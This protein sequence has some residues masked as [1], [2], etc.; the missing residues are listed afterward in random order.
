MDGSRATYGICPAGTASLSVTP[1]GLAITASPVQ[2]AQQLA[3][4]GLPINSGEILMG[5]QT[6]VHVAPGANTQFTFPVIRPGYIIKAH[7]TDITGTTNITLGFID[8][9]WFD[10]PTNIIVSHQGW[11]AFAGAPNTHNIIGSGP[12]AGTEVIVTLFNDSGADTISFD[13]FLYG[14]SVV[15]TRHDWRTDDQTAAYTISGVQTFQSSGS[16]FSNEPADALGMVFSNGVG[17][18]GS[19]TFAIGLFNGK[20]RLWGNTSSGT[21]DMAWEVHDNANWFASLNIVANGKSD[22]NGN[23]D[24][25]FSLDRVQRT[26]KITNNNAAAKNL[27]ITLTIEDY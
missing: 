14:T 8:V 12:T 3:I 17:A 23:I 7:V 20:V 9:Q 6:A 1:Y 26:I 2:I 24:T 21:S 16:G 4:T 15:P 5:Q 25:E 13:I 10:Q 11:G 18:G 19:E 22:S 27:A